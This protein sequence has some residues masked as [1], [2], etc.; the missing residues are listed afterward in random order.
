MLPRRPV[1][2]LPARRNVKEQELPNAPEAQQQGE[3]T[4]AEFREAIRMFSQAVTNQVGQQR[5]ARQEGA[6]TSR[7]REILRMNPPC[8]TGS[9]TTE[10]PKNF[11]EEL[12]KV[13][14]V[15]HVADTERVEL[16]AYQMK[17]VARTWF[18]QLKGVRA[19][20][21]P[22]ARCGRTHPGQCHQGQT[23]CFNCRQEGEF[24]RECPK[25]MQGND[26]AEEQTAYMLS[27][28]AK[29]KRIHQMWSLV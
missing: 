4:N 27:T 20:D 16:A 13:F 6:D 3:V 24:M 5:G 14:D 18:D 8:F 9:S 29:R 21:A 26:S 19:E 17:N 22:P 23:G 7:I 10:D 15:M 12:K 1:R 11:I 25:N 28:V 2:D